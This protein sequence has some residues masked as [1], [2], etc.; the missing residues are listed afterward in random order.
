MKLLSD[1]N[2][3]GSVPK[4]TLLVCQG[5]GRAFHF[6]RARPEPVLLESPPS[7]GLRRLLA[8]PVPNNQPR[9]IPARPLIRD[10]YA[11]APFCTLL[12]ITRATITNSPIIIIKETHTRVLFNLISREGSPVEVSLS[13]N[14]LLIRASKRSGSLP[15]EAFLAS[16]YSKS[17]AI[18]AASPEV[19][20]SPSAAAFAA[21]SAAA[22]SSGVDD[23]FCGELGI[24]GPPR[25]TR[26]GVAPAI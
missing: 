16:S 9:A 17:K 14:I 26:R 2:A 4:L 5:Q 25:L 13:F 18:F 24:Q 11:V 22:A 7:S 19:F 21:A 12:K 3:T 23:V 1:P 15:T 6:P 10:T 20:V 8:A